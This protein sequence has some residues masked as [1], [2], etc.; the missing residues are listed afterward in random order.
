VEGP[1]VLGQ[2]E[3]VEERRGEGVQVGARGH[4]RVDVELVGYGGEVVSADVP[5][6]VFEWLEVVAAVA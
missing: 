4:C 6:A 1:R 5:D 2:P 3:G